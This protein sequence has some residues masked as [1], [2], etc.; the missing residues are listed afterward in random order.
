MV[1]ITCRSSHDS[2]VAH[3]NLYEVAGVLHRDVK[4]DNILIVSDDHNDVSG[5]VIDFDHSIRISDKSPYSNKKKIV[6]TI[7]ISR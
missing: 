1:Y 7:I 6:G 4:P 5:V 3:R 2:Y